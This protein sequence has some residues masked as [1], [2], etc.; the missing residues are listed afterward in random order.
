MNRRLFFN[1]L[2]IG[3]GAASIL[4]ER[5]YANK[6]NNSVVKTPVSI[7][8]WDFK[9]ANFQAGMALESGKDA[10][11]SAIIGANVEEDNPK[12]S[13]VGYGVP[14]IEKVQLH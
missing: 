11:S 2:L 13:T 9:E 6:K 10:L 3:V 12:N 1:S 5:A 4:K 14:Q 7:C 8:T